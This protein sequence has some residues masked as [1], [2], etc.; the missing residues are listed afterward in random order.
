LGQKT[1]AE[2]A[3]LEV[4]LLGACEVWRQGKPI[5]PRIWPQKK[6]FALFKRMVSERGRVFTQEHLIEL[7]Y[8]EWDLQKAT[9]NLF[10]RISEVRRALEPRLKK[11]TASKFIRNAGLDGYCFRP[12]IFC[13]VDL[14]VFQTHMAAGQKAELENRWAQ[15]REHYLRAI[16]LYRGDYLSDDLY[17][18]W[19]QDLRSYWREQYLTGLSRLAESHARLGEFEQAIGLC[20]RVLNVEPGRESVYHQKMLYLSLTQETSTSQD[21]RSRDGLDPEQSARPQVEPVR[22]PWESANGKRRGMYPPPVLTSVRHNLPMPLTSFVGRVRETAE[23]QQLLSQTRLLTLTGLGGSGKTRLALHLVADLVREFPHGIWWIELAPVSDPGLI[24]QSVAAVLNIKSE[25][26]RPLIE[27]LFDYLRNRQLLLILDNCEHL[28]HSCAQ[29]VGRLLRACPSLKVLTTSREILGVPGE[30]VWSVPPL[31][32][33]KANGT[34]HLDS[35]AAA[36]AVR[37]FVERAGSVKPGYQLTE[38][39]AASIAQICQRLDGIPLAI[40]LAAVR[41]NTLSAQEILTRLD[42]CLQLLTGS[43]RAALPRHQTLTAALDWSY[44]LLPAE[45]KGFLARFSVFAKS[46]NLEA[47]ERVCAVAPLRTKQ[48]HAPQRENCNPSSTLNLLTRLV[49]KSLVLADEHENETRYRL[50]EIVRQYSLTKLVRSGKAECL[51]A[52]NLDIEVGKCTRNRHLY[53]YL[54]LAEQ[55][56]AECSGKNQKRWLDRLELEH[57]NLQVALEWARLRPEHQE[58]A[59]RLAGALGWFWEVRGYWEEGYRRLTELLADASRTRQSEGKCNPLRAKWIAKAFTAAGALAWRRGD[60]DQAAALSEKGLGLYQKTGDRRGIASALNVLGLVA[61]Y[62]GEYQRAIGFYQ[63]SLD[64]CRALGDPRGE[65]STLNNL[66]RVAYYQGDHAQAQG[67]LEQSLAL[68]Q[69]LKDEWGMAMVLLLLGEVALAQS[70]GRRAELLFAEGL[71]LCRR[72]GEKRG[73]ALALNLSGAAFQLQKKHNQAIAVLEESIALCRELGD[74]RGLALALD[75]LGVVLRLQGEACRAGM[76][77]KESLALRQALG[78]KRGIADCLE[79]LAILAVVQQDFDRASKLFSAAEA[80]RESIG[81]PLLVYER[82]D[83]NDYLSLLRS[84]LDRSVFEATQGQGRSMSLA[85][86]I[87]Y[88]LEVDKTAEMA[89]NY[90]P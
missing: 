10:K 51:R 26:Q 32:L 76:L 69:A 90:V 58:V 78:D 37:L 68:W 15:A 21:D 40:E 5:S 8:P 82:T 28:V 41:S 64:L 65:A 42:D 63:E 12:K 19:T 77:L 4:N 9:Q 36:D 39:N 61:H 81:A 55:A 27:E 85:Q 46:S 59:L 6:A 56:E 45:E 2:D 70:E 48:R 89:V 18:E 3:I 66:G 43:A 87:S 17:E 14:E 49:E 67:L 20:Q 25:S 62:R 83:H 75:L 23:L 53:F 52:K 35:L 73:I 50:L 1:Q 47:A 34:V 29:W 71:E 54:K 30:I 16:E 44:D 72:L 57:G 74:K 79:N 11:G 88:A 80:L 86:V 31:G 84:R 60:Y 7:F 24:S 22:L 33:P 38:R 13:L